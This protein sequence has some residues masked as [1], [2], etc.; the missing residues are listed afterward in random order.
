MNRI[1]GMIFDMDGLMFDTENMSSE[2]WVKVGKENGFN[3]T[4]ELIDGTRGLDRRKTKKILEDKFGSEFDF[5]W[6]SDKSREYMDAIIEENGM[7]VK[8]GLIELLKYLKANG[9]RCAVASSTERKRVEYYLKRADIEEYF[10]TVIC[11]DDV[12]RGK[13]NPDIFLKAAEKLGIAPEECMVLEDSRYGIEAAFRAEIPVVMIPDMIMPEPDTEK[14]LYD[15]KES[16]LEVID[17]LE[18]Y[19]VRC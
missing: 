10:Y 1:K 17:L 18:E 9:Y 4:R 19:E 15:R 12:S 16:L 3:I 5:K 14:M 13:P 2:C 6:F 7:P 8:K 11:G